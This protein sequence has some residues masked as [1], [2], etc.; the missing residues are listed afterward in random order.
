MKID[1]RG[2]GERLLVGVFNP[3]EKILVKWECSHIRDEHKTIIIGNHHL[4]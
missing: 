4:D 2:L 3:S 1:M